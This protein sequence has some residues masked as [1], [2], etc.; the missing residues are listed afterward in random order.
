[1]VTPTAKGGQRAAKP[2]CLKKGGSCRPQQAG[3]PILGGGMLAQTAGGANKLGGGVG[4][5]PGGGVGV[6]Y[7]T[8]LER[9]GGDPNLMCHSYSLLNS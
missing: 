8:K 6:T 4:N 9:I 1:M 7:D 3:G 2:K 5:E